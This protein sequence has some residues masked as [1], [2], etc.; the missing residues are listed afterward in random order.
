MTIAPIQRPALL[1]LGAL[2]LASSPLLAK[3]IARQGPLSPWDHRKE[4]AP[5]GVS[6][7]S[8]MVL[9]VPLPALATARDGERLWVEDLSAFDCRGVSI[10]Q[11]SLTPALRKDGRVRLDP[12]LVFHAEA[13]ADARASV[14][15]ELLDGDQVV[16]GWWLRDFSTM[17]GHGRA[18]KITNAV[19]REET[20]RGVQRGRP[21][22][23]L[24]VE[25]HGA[26]KRSEAPFATR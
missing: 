4:G 16:G 5:A 20:F 9:D 24:T 14:R 15:L 7:Q 19:L 10:H 8:P 3:V 18:G 23:R 22:L 6:F 17:E 12:F 13:G 11:L 2:L 26:E 1:M 25:T 21:A